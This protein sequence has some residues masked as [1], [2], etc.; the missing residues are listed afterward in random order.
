MRF[1]SLFFF[2]LFCLFLW[3]PTASAQKRVFATVDPNA[4]VTNSDANIYDPASGAITAAAGGMNVARAG[5]VAVRLG[6]GRILLAGGY[7]GHYLKSVEIYDPASGTFASAGDMLTTRSGGAAVLLQGGA[8]LVVGGYNG[9]YLNLSELYDPVTGTFTTA[10]LMSVERQNPAIVRLRDGNVLVTGGFGGAGFNA[11][12]ELYNTASRTYSITGSMSS[13]REGHTATLLSNGNVLITGGCNNAQTVKVVCDRYLASAEIYDPSTNAFTATGSMDTARMDHT[14]TLLPDGKVLI[15]GGTNGTSPLASAEIYNPATGTF[16]NIGNMGVS[17][18]NHTASS[19]PNGKVLIAGGLSNQHLASAEVFN[20]DTG[21]FT[22]VSSPMTV[23]R[24]QHSATALSDGRILLAGGENSTPL[25]FDVNYQAISDNISPNIVFSAD[26]K[27]GFVPYTGSGVVIAFSAE[28]GAVIERIVTGGKPAFITPLLDGQSLAVVSALD[29]RVFIIDMGS[30]SVKATYTFTGGFGFGSIISL[31][32]DG[33]YGYVSS[34]ETGEVIKFDV[35]TGS[36][37]GRLGNLDEPAQITVTKDGS[38]LLIVDVGLSEV[39]FADSQSMT[40]KHKVAPVS[41]YTDANFTIF[42]KAVLNL[43]ETQG[44]IGSQDAD[45]TLF[46]FDASTGE[47]LKAL[48]VG[49]G[50][51]FATLLPSGTHWVVLSQDNLSVVPTEDPSSGI[52]GPIVAGD[53]LGSANV[54]FSDD[55]RYAYYTS[56]TTD[57]I[58]QHEIDTHAIV[59]LYLTGDDP[60]ISLDQASSLAVTPDGTAMAVLNFLSN[61][62]DLLS[63]TTVLKQTKFSSQDDEFTGLTIINLSDTPTDV[64]VTAISNGGTVLYD[65]ND[66]AIDPVT[67]QLDPNAQEALDVQQLFDM[68][69]DAANTGRLVIESAQPLIAGFT[70]VGRVR[71]HF[72]NPFIGEMQGI[73]FNP[74]YREKLHDWI[75]PEY[76][77]ADGASTELNFVNPNYSNASYDITHYALDGTVIEA[78]DDITI[79]ASTR[80]TIPASSFVAASQSGKVLIHGGIDGV[81]TRNT[82]EL[83]THSGQRFDSTSTASKTPRYGHTAVSLPNEKILIAGGKN[84]RTILKSAELFDPAEQNFVSTP[85]SMISERYRHTATLLANGIVLIAGGQNSVSISSTA[86]LF[87]PL[88]GS[89]AATAGSMISPR[90]AHTATLLPD[91]KVLLTG[92]LDG[93]AVSATA[94]IFDPATSQFY[95]TGSMN[96]PRAFHT[97][98]A[99]SNGKVLIAGGYNGSYLNSAELYN[100]SAGSFELISPMLTERSGHTGTLLSEGAVLIAGGINSSG[101]L[102][103]AEIYDPDTGLFSDINGTMVSARSFHTATLLGDDTEG[104][105]DAVLLVGGL[106]YA[107]ETSEALETLSTAEIFAPSTRQFTQTSLGLN[108]PRQRHSATLLT[109]GNQGYFR[110]T[111]VEGLLFTEIYSNGGASTSINGIDM[112]RYVGVTRIYSPLFA[113]SPGFETWLNVINGNQESEAVVTITL[114]AADGSVLADPITKIFPKNAQL[115]GNLWEIFGYDPLLEGRAGWLE[116]TSS[117]DGIVGTYSYT[118]SEK[119]FLVTYELSGIP[120]DRF[121]FP[122]VSEDSDFMTGIALLNSGNQPANVQLELWSLEGTLDETRMVTLNPG[123]HISRMLIQLFPGMQPHRS[124][125]VRVY[126]DQPL[127]GLGAMFGSDFRFVLSVPPVAI[128]EQ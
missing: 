45:G 111:S 92:G 11:S 44:V 9:T 60:N 26:S 57:L 124:G 25:L 75:I 39:V 100:P 102:N 51:G 58:S 35:S 33:N 90:D 67:I 114:H 1:R 48:V 30:R 62:L 68:N 110:G 78:S 4:A 84:G 19:L 7:N 88:S 10:G 47:I 122:L 27:V 31:S 99:L 12:A 96:V 93:M 86:E 50:P 3:S 66:D 118:D 16:A 38:T 70:S 120:M 80:S 20:P 22:T 83:Y 113:I 32:P 79:N 41:I 121:V 64:T 116:V 14:A 29:N 15:V 5:H 71:A 106:G 54:L 117:E 28:T 49:Y 73:P 126:S 76:P 46:V 69:Y 40:V 23:P 18:S 63:D 61:R 53:P 101:Y 77:Q 72:L 13:A 125:N 59:G 17:R 123:T 56:S 108:Y 37:V 36:E 107:D 6:G 128:P 85:G 42:N 87:D 52:S 8:V 89:F 95:P 103:V 112:G 65:A 82:S 81:K 43:D 55:Y 91:G 34:T 24:S 109:A 127:H 98:V 74:D 104:V 105:N 97:A 2:L 115:K 94:E 119:K 21:T